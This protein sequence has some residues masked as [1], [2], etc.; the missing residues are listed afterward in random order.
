MTGDEAMN[1]YKAKFTIFDQIVKLQKQTGER[2][3]DSE[4]ARRMGITRQTFGALMKGDVLRI[5]IETINKLLSFFESEGMP[6]TI[7]D[8]FTVATEDFPTKEK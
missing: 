8:L 5:E 2:L 7:A 1:T 3:S 4:Y 6:I